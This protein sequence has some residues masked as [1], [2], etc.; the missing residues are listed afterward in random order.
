MAPSSLA[1]GVPGA[2]RRQRA[3]EH[4]RQSAVAFEL[5][6]WPGV[7]EVEDRRVE[8]VAAGGQMEDRSGGIIAVDL[9]EEA[10][11][12][13]PLEEAQPLTNEDSGL[14]LVDVSNPSAP[15]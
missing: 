14:V 4:F 9:V 6:E 5:A 15:P 7:A 8:L 10:A 2:G 1:V 11:A 3:V 13:I 12:V